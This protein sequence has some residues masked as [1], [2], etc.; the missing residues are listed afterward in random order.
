MT[1]Y[2]TTMIFTHLKRLHVYSVF[3]TSIFQHLPRLKTLFTWQSRFHPKNV[4]YDETCCSPLL[5]NLTVSEP[6]IFSGR[7]I[8]FTQLQKLHLLNVCYDDLNLPCLSNLSQLKLFHYT[9]NALSGN[10]LVIHGD[11]FPASLEEIHFDYCNLFFDV[12]MRRLK[13]LNCIATTDCGTDLRQAWKEQHLP[14]QLISCYSSHFTLQCV[15]DL[16]E[17]L[18]EE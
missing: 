15:S 2:D 17:V 8:V 14:P 4:L 7:R 10:V 11:L 12:S 18:K 16:Y 1:C 3:L 5:E 13:A 9:R 6:E